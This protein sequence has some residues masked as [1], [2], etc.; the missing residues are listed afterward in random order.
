VIPRFQGS[1][2]RLLAAERYAQGRWDDLNTRQ[3]NALSAWT[4]KHAQERAAR[5]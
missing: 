1:V 3:S 5:G 4:E 2:D